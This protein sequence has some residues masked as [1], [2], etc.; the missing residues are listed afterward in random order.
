MSTELKEKTYNPR[1][2]HG[3]SFKRVCRRFAEKTSLLGVS[4][5]NSSKKRIATFIWTFLFLCAM[6]AMLAHLYYLT[7][8]FFSWPKQTEVTLEFRNLKFPAVTICNVNTIRRSKL[9]LAKQP[10]QNLIGTFEDVMQGDRNGDDRRR[11]KK[12]FTE[13][14]D[15]INFTAYDEYDYYV[16]DYEDDLEDEWIAPHEKSH[17][18]MNAFERI[19]MKE[20]RETRSQMGHQ[21]DDM[22]VSCSFDGK[23]CYA[24]NFTASD[25]PEYGNC[26]TLDS[27]KFITKA[28]GPRAGLTLIMYMENDEYLHGITSGFGARFAIH[29]SDTYPFPA[30]EGAFVATRSETH[31]GLRLVKI[32]RIVYP[33]GECEPGKEFKNRFNF[34]YT[35]QA[36][37]V[38]CEQHTAITECGCYKHVADEITRLIDRGGA[39]PC[40]TK[41]DVVC[42][43]RTL[44]SKA[45]P[46]L[47]PCSEDSYVKATST[48]QW[49]TAM[50][51]GFLEHVFCE[52][53]PGKCG[54][55]SENEDKFELSLNLLK[56]VI[57]YEDLNYEIITE[58]AAITVW[59]FL[60]DI[61]GAAGL[62]IGLSFLSCFE[63]I[64]FGVEI[65]DYLIWKCKRNKGVLGQ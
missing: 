7:Q 57:Y 45:C 17:Q 8:Q 61:G 18:A 39:A 58:T 6:V 19:Y 62:W 41:E 50:Y 10:L 26:F 55:I 25:T 37:M 36:C 49:P 30:D 32:Q 65:V 23:L 43:Q 13:R 35:R 5:I 14:F 54:N 2:H 20:S 9:H 40:S 21:I 28:P 46:C 64:Q 1:S 52:E 31:V 59:Q 60:S 48:R 63:V 3:K 56:L 22:L 34:T 27:E 44:N 12:R 42:L 53:H 16:Y 4:Y 47:Y 11:R 38:L 29:D 51:A 33:W 24:D 15:E